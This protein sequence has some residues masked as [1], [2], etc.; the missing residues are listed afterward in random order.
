M[1]PMGLKVHLVDGTYELFRHY[2]AVPSRQNSAGEEVGAVRG[3]VSSML[4]LLG[5]GATHVGVATDHVIESWRN[6]MWPTYKDSTG[7]MP[8]LSL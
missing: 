1:L 6:D 5:D 2:F 3:V 4:A 7:S 8:E